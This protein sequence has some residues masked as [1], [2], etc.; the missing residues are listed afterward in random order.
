MDSDVLRAILDELSHLVIPP[1]QLA[2][3][4]DAELG[5]GG[6]GEVYLANLTKSSE[7]P[8]E[9]VAVKQLRIVQSREVR[10]RIAI[11]LVRELKVWAAA[12]HPNILELVGFYLSENYGCAQLI[13]TYIA[14]GNVKDYIKT[15]NPD[16]EVRL[17]L[18]KGITSGINH[19]HTR[20]PP[21]CHG[22]LKPPNV[23]VNHNIEAVLC[24]F[25]LS[26][27]INE[28]GAPSGLTT[29]KSVK[30]STRY[31]S[32]EL[33]QE[34]GATH[35]L[36]SDMWAWAC[37]VFE[38]VT[39]CQPYHTAVG[40]VGVIRS[41][42][43][44]KPP[45]LV[46]MLDNISSDADATC[47]RALNA[48]KD[49][50]PKCWIYDSVKR[51]PSSEIMTQLFFQRD[52][53]TPDAGSA[54]DQP[55]LIEPMDEASSS[56]TNTGG[57]SLAPFSFL[58]SLPRR[59]MSTASPLSGVSSAI[60]SRRASVSSSRS[61]EV[62]HQLHQ[63]QAR[64][65]A[66][67]AA[68]A[69]AAP[70]T[71]ASAQ[72]GESSEEEVIHALTQTMI[73]EAMYKYTRRVVGGGYGKKRHRRFF[74]MNP[75][76]KT[77]YWSVGDPGSV[78]ANESTP[79]TAYVESVKA[80]MELNPLPPALYHYSI[81]VS[82]P[83]REI[84]FTAL[85]KERHD[86]WYT[87]LKYLLDRPSSIP[88]NEPTNGPPSRPMASP[89][90]RT[91]SSE[92]GNPGNLMT[93]P[94]SIH[95]THSDSITPR[96]M[97]S[98]TRL[99]IQKAQKSPTPSVRSYRQGAGYGDD[100]DDYE[101]INPAGELSF[102]LNDEGFKAMENVRACCDGEHD[103]GTR[104]RRPASRQHHRH[105]GPVGNLSRPQTPAERPPSLS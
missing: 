19:L 91:F 7:T 11:R 81:V 82:T 88:V 67:A 23:L 100:D 55:L 37:T 18:V 24:D 57:G 34:F 43:L 47:H 16:L 60:A 93:S 40:D 70:V 102:E 63:P 99:T 95:S 54:P 96:A 75:Y 3:E 66:R 89:H 87:A 2:F 14:H 79:K 68:T 64:T 15:C 28:S 25:G 65:P 103:L 92:D 69:P 72:T 22:D 56:P 48:L 21:I 29:S 46:S 30:G 52:A 31:M 44:G 73:G 20:D 51:P 94:R 17:N 45:G 32:P 41:S 58:S 50:I 38:V 83:Q 85:N 26:T 13:S 105:N 97:R 6:Y 101:A 74:W 35:T 53:K 62:H 8:P 42:V 59:E 77:L 98:Q 86:I 61:S 49:V 76:T 1:S 90:Q 12:K 78:S 5:C 9:K 84:K 36:G 27:F 39:D 33:L 71:P 4:N 104:S 80:I 10:R